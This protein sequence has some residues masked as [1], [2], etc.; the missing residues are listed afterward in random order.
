MRIDGYQNR[1]VEIGNSFLRFRPDLR[2][3]TF[4]RIS[5]LETDVE[6]FSMT[7]IKNLS[8]LSRQV[9]NQIAKCGNQ[10]V[11][12]AD[13]IFFVVV[14]LINLILARRIIAYFK[15]DAFTVAHFAA[16]DIMQGY[17]RPI[18]G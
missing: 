10:S 11:R 7:F 1:R 6:F 18:Q 16:P 2:V 12:S 8:G 5:A 14:T 17:C 9:L 3:K 15:T 4:R 13:Q